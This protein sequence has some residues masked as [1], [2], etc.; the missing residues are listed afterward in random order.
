MMPEERL[1]ANRGR[2]AIVTID[3]PEAR[4]AR[5]RF[6]KVDAGEDARDGMR[7]VAENR[8]PERKD[9]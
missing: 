8:E 6:H 2:V 4:D 7:A 1:Y 5:R 3:R 9:T